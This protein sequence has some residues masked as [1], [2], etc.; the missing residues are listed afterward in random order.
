[1]ED[2]TALCIEGKLEEAKKYLREKGHADFEFKEIE[3][4]VE[5]CFIK[6]LKEQNERNGNNNK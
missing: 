4:T 6:L 5:D 2:F 1:M 3:P